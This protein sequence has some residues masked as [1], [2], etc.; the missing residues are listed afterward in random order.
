V[1][2][3]VRRM[4]SCH[5]TARRL[6]RYLDADPSVP[7][8]P[9]EIRRLEEHLAGCAPCA[10]AVADFSSM[11]R[12]MLVLSRLVGPDRTAVARLHHVVDQLLEED[13]R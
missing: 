11:R 10:S 13:R 5:F 3:E 9:A 7:L 12:A 8:D 2:S 6:Q 1:I 4:M